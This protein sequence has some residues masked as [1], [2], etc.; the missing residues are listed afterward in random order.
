MKQDMFDD[1]TRGMKA[2][3]SKGDRSF[4]V[5]FTIGIVKI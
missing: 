2:G 5:D 4:Q 1:W 3:S